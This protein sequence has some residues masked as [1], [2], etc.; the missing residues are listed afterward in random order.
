MVCYIDRNIAY[1]LS[2]AELCL[3]FM[4]MCN[5][6]HMVLCWCRWWQCGS[7]VMLWSPSGMLR[8]VFAA[9]TLQY[10]KLLLLQFRSGTILVTVY[11]QV[12]DLRVLRAMPMLLYL[13]TAHFFVFTVFTFYSFFLLLGWG[14]RIDRASI[15]F[16]LPCIADLYYNNW[17]F[18]G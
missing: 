17:Y 14:L 3:L 7:H 13:P 1:R 9:R 10:R 15:A 16:S 18:T 8:W 5:P 11:L 12:W 6:I 2:A 4:I